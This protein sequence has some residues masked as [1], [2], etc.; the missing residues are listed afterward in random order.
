MVLEVGGN[1]CRSGASLD[2]LEDTVVGRRTV[3]HQVVGR[4]KLWWMG[5]GS[6]GVPFAIHI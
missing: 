6:P 3:L 5:V 1:S 2:G 4:T